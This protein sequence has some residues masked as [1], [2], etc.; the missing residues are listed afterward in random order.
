LSPLKL[1]LWLPLN[2]NIVMKFKSVYT[3]LIL[4]VVIFGI[5]Y[6][7]LDNLFVFDDEN[8]IVAN[9]SIK[10]IKFI[11]DYFVGDEGFHKVIGRYYRPVVFSTYAIDYSIWGLEPFGFHLTNILIHTIA[12][13]VLFSLLKQFFGKDKTGVTAALA[14]SLV[15]AVHTIHTEAV[16]W[17]SGRTDSIVAIFYFASLLYF[18]K[19]RREGKSNKLLYLSAGFYL[20]GLFSKEMIFTF[21]LIAIIYDLIIG[22]Q[23]LKALIKKPKP[24]IFFIAVTVF[25]LILRHMVLSDFPER[26]NYL[27]FIGKDKLIVFATMLKTIPTYLKLMF[28]PVNLLYHYNGVIPDAESLTEFIVLVSA[29]VT[30]GFIFYAIE[31]REN[32]P[33]LSFLILFFF[34]S[35]LPVL[36][37]IP[38]MNLMAERFLYVPS[39][40]IAL[41]TG[42]IFFKIKDNKY[43]PVAAIGLL[44]VLIV[45]AH[46]TIERNK[47][48]K[49]NE[50]LF[51]T[52]EGVEGNLLLVNDGNRYANK[53]QYDEAEKRYKRAIEIRD[54]SILA[55]H[56]LGLIYMLRNQLDSAE[57]EF[58]RG[59]EIDPLAPD[60]YFQLSSI[61]RMKGELKKAEE[62]L[63][64]LQKIA[65]DYKGTSSL[66]AGIRT[67]IEPDV[68]Y[69]KNQL[70]NI[71]GRQSYQFF[72]QGKY[73]EA[74][75]L[76]EELIQL[77]PGECVTISE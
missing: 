25:Y 52:A 50:T 15:F 77:K 66:L 47:D 12:T 39:F 32:L 45:L 69:V 70:A 33:I 31:V 73:D 63:S 51:A 27:Y 2:C 60:G 58:K 22:K 18:I 35:L 34:I 44:V 75:S 3:Y 65:P 48:W 67:G 17:I 4:A 61:Y 5:Y 8:L 36:N 6:N 53:Q 10:G 57:Y 55:H 38:T 68:D 1:R 40:A 43:K 13:L 26:E 64:Q 24:Y 20:L 11:P 7:S 19:Y 46:L 42:W 76:L 37:I 56:N 72:G 9:E 74:I 62:Y 16:A 59:I 30:V 23:T 71:K 14:G 54:N 41:F 21:P 28:Y 49:D 29:F